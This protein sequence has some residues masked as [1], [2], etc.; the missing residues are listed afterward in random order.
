[1]EISI[2]NPGSQEAQVDITFHFV[3]RTTAHSL[4]VP[5]QSVRTVF[6][7][8]AVAKNELFSP[9]VKSDVPV[10]VQQVRRAYTR[11]IPLTDSLWACLAHPFGPGDR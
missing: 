5:G 9:I 1:M 7:L 4:N 6:N 11:G 8:P 2:L 3:D 10:V